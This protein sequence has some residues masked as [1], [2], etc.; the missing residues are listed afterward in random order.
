MRVLFGVCQCIGIYLFAKGFLLSKLEINDI[1]TQET[2]ENNSRF[3]RSIIVLSDALRFDFCMSNSTGNDHFSSQLSVIP[4][5]LE[6]QPFNSLLFKSFADPPT[7][8]M[9]RVLIYCNLNIFY[10]F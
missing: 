8:T 3:K 9:Q 5:L 6:S 10:S 7:T 2:S 1:A 4:E